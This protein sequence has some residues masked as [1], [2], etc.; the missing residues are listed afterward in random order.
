MLQ[1]RQTLALVRHERDSWKRTSRKRRIKNQSLR[2]R[3]DTLR[4][5]NDTLR[6]QNDTLCTENQRLKKRLCI[7]GSVY[8]ID[9]VSEFVAHKGNQISQNGNTDRKSNLGSLDKNINAKKSCHLKRDPQVGC[10]KTLDTT[11]FWKGHTLCKKCAK[12][13]KRRF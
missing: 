8:Q 5:Q 12:K 11:E 2:D 1:L 13:R 9:A 4:D 6:D 7:I 3:N 10:K